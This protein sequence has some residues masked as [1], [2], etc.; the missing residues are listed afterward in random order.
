MKFLTI[1]MSLLSILW[2]CGCASDRTL[3]EHSASTSEI[4]FVSPPYVSPE[5]TDYQ[6][7]CWGNKGAQITK[8]I[9]DDNDHTKYLFTVTQSDVELMYSVEV[10]YSFGDY[11]IFVFDANGTQIQMIEGTSAVADMIAFV[12]FNLDGYADLQITLTGTQNEPHLIYLWN[13]DACAF[14]ELICDGPLYYYESYVGYV[15]NW[16]KDGSSCVVVQK[17][18]WDG[19]NS[20]VLDSEERIDLEDTP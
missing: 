8:E 10:K 1:L 9:L 18:V 3:D 20:L 19:K 4:E 5:L 2:T 6:I 16:I 14:S 7:S 15:K 11:T 13:P 17:L 12:D